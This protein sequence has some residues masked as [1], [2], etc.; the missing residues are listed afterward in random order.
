MRRGAGWLRHGSG[1]VDGGAVGR[2]DERLAGI[3]EPASRDAGWHF[4]IVL[5]GPKAVGEPGEVPDRGRRGRR[6]L[7]RRRLA[8]AAI[9][10]QRFLPYLE[11]VGGRAEL[12]DGRRFSL[13]VFRM[14]D[15]AAAVIALRDSDVRQGVVEAVVHVLGAAAVRCGAGW[16][17]RKSGIGDGSAVGREGAAGRNF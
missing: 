13:D 4:A 6:A 8:R 17:T 14:S 1:I 7:P 11:V 3:S 15:G 2:D 10:C 16:L 12:R 5:H 9:W